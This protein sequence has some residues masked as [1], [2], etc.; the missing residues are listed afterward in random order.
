MK[1][2]LSG[3]AGVKRWLLD[4]TIQPEDFYALESFYS[5]HDWQ[6]PMI[7]RFKGFLLDSGAFTFMGNAKK[8][9]SVDWLS[10]ADKY[11]D[12][13]NEHDVK[14][15]FELDIDQ[16]KGLKYAEM[17]R[18]RIEDR[19]HRKSIPVWHVWRGKQYYL[20]LL[21][22]Y[23][24]VAFGGLLTDG[25]SA[26]KLEPYFPWFI[27]QAHQK[28]VKIHGLGY[29]RLDGLPKYKFDSVDSTT[30]LMSQRF[31]QVQEFKNGTIIK[32]NSVENG[33]KKR[34]IID[35]KSV[36]LHDFKEWVKY[37]KYADKYF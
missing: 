17:L 15:F 11:A 23:P 6:K 25:F 28:G 35:Q 34:S 36:L 13:I 24:Y 22:D 37:Q 19:T 10:Y 12:F 18:Q 8:H 32:H 3:I 20:D 4:G 16:L 30:W 31:G 2:Y 1:I 27:N 14:L 29:T 5:F 33:V 9:G 21:E 26:K 7:K